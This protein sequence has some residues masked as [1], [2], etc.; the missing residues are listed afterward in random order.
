[1]KT[2]SREAFFK[3]LDLRKMQLLDDLK[4]AEAFQNM[5]EINTIIDDIRTI[6]CAI[7]NFKKQVFDKVNI[8]ETDSGGLS[9]EPIITSNQ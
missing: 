4:R 9:F 7:S 5:P 8:D 1:M 2:V 3:I 6:D